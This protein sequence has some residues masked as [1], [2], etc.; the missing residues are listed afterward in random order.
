MHIIQCHAVDAVFVTREEAGGRGGGVT[1]LCCANS[2]CASQCAGRLK[3]RN[4]A[5]IYAVCILWSIARDVEVI[6]G[7]STDNNPAGWPIWSQ[8]EEGENKS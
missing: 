5:L 7:H 3:L 8:K 6:G 2:T 1:T 4:I